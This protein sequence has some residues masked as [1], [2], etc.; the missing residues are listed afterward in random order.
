MAFSSRFPAIM[1]KDARST[2]AK[3]D[4]SSYLS[5]QIVPRRNLTS[6]GLST[7]LAIAVKKGGIWGLLTPWPQD[8]VR[9]NNPSQYATGPAV[10]K[11]TRNLVCDKHSW[12]P[13]WQ[14]MAS[15]IGGIHC[16][17]FGAYRAAP[18]SWGINTWWGLDAV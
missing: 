15:M 9:L 18:K 16:Y 14:L 11:V 12:Q 6:I 8:A 13:S 17:S 10:K 5:S 2:Y 4:P 7:A 3:W 1:V